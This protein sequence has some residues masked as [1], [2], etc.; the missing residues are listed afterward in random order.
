MITERWFDRYLFDRFGRK[1]AAE[2]SDDDPVGVQPGR[3]GRRL[4]FFDLHWL[5]VLDGLSQF[6]DPLPGIEGL[7]SS[8][9]CQILRS[10]NLH[11]T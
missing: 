1:G 3:Q 10:D 4:G 9:D 11:V 5:S 7:G 8:T 6:V 2:H